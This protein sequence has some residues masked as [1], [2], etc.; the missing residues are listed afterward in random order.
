MNLPG[1]PHLGVYRMVTA[2]PPWAYDRPDAPGGTG[3]H[4]DGMP[5]EDICAMRVGDLA[6]PQ[7]AV[8][9]LWCTGPF[10]ADGDLRGNVRLFGDG[11]ARSTIADLMT[12]GPTAPHIADPKVGRNEPCPCGSGAKTKRCTPLHDATNTE[13]ATDGA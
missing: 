6:H 7:G 12:G 9:G 5:L 11:P 8:L 13:G 1:M 10:V 4:Y 3:E 2:D